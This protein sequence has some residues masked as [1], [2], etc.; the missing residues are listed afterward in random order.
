MHVDQKRELPV[1]AIYVTAVVSF[2]LAAINFGSDVGKSSIL[3]P[4]DDGDESY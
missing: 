2:I 3:H 4:M 1:N